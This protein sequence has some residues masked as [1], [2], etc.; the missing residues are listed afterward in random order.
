MSCGDE[1]FLLLLLLLLVVLTRNSMEE[2]EEE[3]FLLVDANEMII[4][5]RRLF[6]RDCCCFK[7]AFAKRRSLARVFVLD[8]D[9]S[10]S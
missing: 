6:L 10:S 4:D 9:D 5:L 1:D 8:G 7:Q 3:A 2:E